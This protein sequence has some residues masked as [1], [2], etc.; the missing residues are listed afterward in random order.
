ML[1]S[2]SG[3]RAGGRD[4]RCIWPHATV[5][6][7][8]TL[9]DPPAPLPA[10]HAPGHGSSTRR[11]GVIAGVTSVVLV[12]G[13]V[14]S[15]VGFDANRHRSPATSAPPGIR[16]V[17][18]PGG[19]TQLVANIT[20]GPTQAVGAADVA[21][22]ATA[23]EAFTLELTRLELADAGDQ[24]VL[25]SPMSAHLDLSMLELGS[26]GAT[27]GEIAA[28]L[29]SAGVSPAEQAATWS[30]LVQHLMAGESTGEL[31]LANS[32]WV[33]DGLHVQSRFLEEAAHAFGNDT[34][35]VDFGSSSAAQA[36]NSWVAN[37][38]KGRITQLFAPGQLPA[39]TSF[40]LAN[41]LR[42]HAAWQPG[43]FAGAEIATEPFHTA[44]S[45]SVRV[46]TLVAPQSRL[47][48]AKG[49]G[50]E[51]VELPY[52]NGRFAALLVEPTTSSLG[53]W[54]GSLSVARLSAIVGSLRSGYVDFSMPVLHLSA[55]GNLDAP[56]SSM[57]MGAAFESADFSPLIGAD[58]G[59]EALAVVQQAAT[60]DVNKWGTDAAAAT[61]TVAIPVDRLLAPA[62]SF[63]H[64]Y[65]F[66]IRD[67]A[68][69]TILF[70]SVVD[71]PADA[72]A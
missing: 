66:L 24:N 33:Q 2:N 25:L 69:G 59:E 56:L 30:T 22:L 46:P 31:T 23:E 43:L 21:G 49:S 53:S 3:L 16:V 37:A 42:F 61:G 51:A 65:L 35:Q 38:T 19:S 17:G 28:A 60:L 39:A 62:I 13:L 7:M 57:G 50:Y 52:T 8:K 6:W 27:A 40:V 26:A 9:L 48:F 36:I 58:G 44:A 20:S 41:T 14:I 54:L 11:R 12:A 34:Y 10:E 67:T 15:V 4:L 29:Q 32:V 55:D 5:E 64:P 72:A 1:A 68:T 71:D 47:S 63:D 45:G 70:S 18:G